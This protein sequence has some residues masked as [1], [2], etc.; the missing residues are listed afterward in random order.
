MTQSNVI[1]GVIAALLL[2]PTSPAP[3]LLSQGIT[4]ELRSVVALSGTPELALCRVIETR[5]V[6]MVPYW[7]SSPG[8]VLSDAPCNEARKWAPP[9]PV[10]VL[11]AEGQIDAAVP[12]VPRLSAAE[13]AWGHLGL[14][15]VIGFA[16]A[17]LTGALMRWRMRRVRMEILGLKD[18]PV[19]LM[20]DAMCHAAAVDPDPAAIAHIRDLARELTDLD[21]TSAHIEAVIDRTEGLRKPGDFHRFGVTLNARQKAMLLE[22]VLSVVMADGRL[23]ETEGRFCRNMVRGLRLPRSEAWAARSRVL[24]RRAAAAPA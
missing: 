3:A 9:I 10:A 4:T 16:L 18:G 24:T 15:L 5:R 17:T 14:L 13:R 20:I 21:Y 12:D 7:I 19:F 22:G 2:L 23:R 8:Y 6:G 11:K 1:A